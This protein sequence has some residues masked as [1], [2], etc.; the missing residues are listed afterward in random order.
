MIAYPGGI[1]LPRGPPTE[2]VT[3]VHEL[4]RERGGV[5][6]AFEGAGEESMKVGVYLWVAGAVMKATWGGKG[7]LGL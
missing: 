2:R 5:I 4:L 3:G 7:L 6:A 1:G